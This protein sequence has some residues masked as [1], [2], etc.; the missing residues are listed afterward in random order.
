MQK[1]RFPFSP[2]PV[3]WFAVA[4]S[5][6]LPVGG[7]L[8][9]SVLGVDLVAFRGQD[10]TPHVLDAYCPHLGAHLG[11]GGVVEDNCIRCPFH[12]WTFSGDGECT[13]IPY[14]KKIPPNARLERWPVSERNGFLFVHHHPFAEAP[15]WDVPSFSEVGS[16][17]WTP[18]EHI[19]WKIRTNVH[20][21]VENAFDSAHFHILHKMKSVPSSTL[22]F[23]GP[24]WRMVNQTQ[25]ETPFGTG[26][27]GQ[28]DIHSYGMGAGTAR[29]TGLIETLLFANQTPIDDEY[30]DAR[31]AFTVKKLPNPDATDMVRQGFR[32]ELTREVEQDIRIW[33]H[34]RFR[35]RPV[36][37][38]GDGPIGQFRKWVKQFYLEGAPEVGRA[39]RLPQAA[40]E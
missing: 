14:A 13:R 22:E 4:Y 35:E 31:F 5:H 27:D 39:R 18:L 25:M 6:E 36:L 34:K 33:E 1:R 37:C 9:L 21:M 26:M 10:G 7:V 19:R 16:D 28:L 32:D 24:R 38:D 12:A 29:L 17:E 8:P 15:T 3:G 20:E 40:A 11:H 30:L 23:D 2:Y